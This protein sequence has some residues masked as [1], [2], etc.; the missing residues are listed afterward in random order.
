LRRKA[1]S[2]IGGRVVELL[3]EAFDR[4]LNFRFVEI[5]CI[6]LVRIPRTFFAAMVLLYTQSVARNQ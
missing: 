1:W 4:N 5:L 6:L 2:I 3:D